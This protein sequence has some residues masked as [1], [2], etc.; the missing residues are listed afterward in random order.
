MYYSYAQIRKAKGEK[1]GWFHLECDPDIA[2]YYEYFYRLGGKRWFPPLNGCHLTV[3]A[4]EKDDRIIYDSELSY[5]YDKWIPFSYWP[6]IRTNGRA[7]WLEA[8]S[9]CAN[10]LRGSLGLKMRP[11]FHV[12]LGNIKNVI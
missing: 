5:W 7:F 4:G 3:I 12:T 1:P 6:P 11:H 9:P 2:K 10:K 8:D